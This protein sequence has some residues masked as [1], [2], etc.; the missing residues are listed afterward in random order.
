MKAIIHRLFN[1]PV[2][3][4][5]RLAWVDYL[6]GI[7]IILVVYRHALLGI[8]RGGIAINQHLENANMIFFSFRMPLF[9]ILSGIFI[10]GS[11]KKKTVAQ[12]IKSK[13]NLLLY[14][15][16]IWTVLQITLQIIA[17]PLVN[18][19]RGLIDYTYIF[20]QP[21]NLDQF[22]YLP[23]L[24][25]ATVVYVLLK[26]IRTPQWLQLALGLGLYF[27]SPHLES[28]SMLSDWMK[29]YFFFALGDSISTLFFSGKVQ[30][31][32]NNPL[33]LL[34]V[35]PA[36]I[37]AQSYYVS[38][39]VSPVLFLLIALTGCVSMFILS[40]QFQRWQ[41][42]A[43][44]RVLG[45]HSLYIYVMHVMVVGVLRSLLEN[46]LHVTN[47]YL[48]LGVCITGG[49]IIPV[50]C[51]NLFIQSPL[52]SLLFSPKKAAVPSYVPT[53]QVVIAPLVSLE[54]TRP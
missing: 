47:P 25:N 40:F 46:Y 1:L 44:L 52:L 50:I 36:F 26:T 32:L 43:F 30:K 41:L 9:F 51:Y 10:G 33:S 4:K 8:E 15:Y 2:L 42:L 53:E 28:I 7:A 22:W 20:Y 6:K 45:Y 29:F 12:F 31:L 3:Q 24:F 16:I 27:V 13:F 14:P 39:A 5:S 23:A 17:S 11:L 38:H 54:T 19:N 21:R 35:T 37:V 18:A 34:A 49:V 48:L